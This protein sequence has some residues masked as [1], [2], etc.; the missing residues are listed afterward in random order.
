MMAQDQAKKNKDPLLNPFANPTDDPKLPR[1]L[2]V[3]DSISVG[4][5]TRVRRLLQGKANV[6][7][8]GTNCRWSAFGDENIQDWMK[9]S[10]WD[11]IH[12]NF[13]LWD[14]YGWKQEVKATPESYADR[15]NSIVEK[16]KPTGANLIFALTTPPCVGSERSAKIIVSQER[17][18]AFNDAAIE[19]M[20]R[21]EV[22]IND[23]YTAVGQ[24]RTKYQKA[25]NDVH[26]NDEGRDVLAAKVAST[27]AAALGKRKSAPTKRTARTRVKKPDVYASS[28]PKPTFSEVRYGKHKRHVIDFWQ[29]DSDQPAPLVFVIHGGGWK[30]GSKE[31]VDRFANVQKMLDY[32]ISVAA[33]NYRYVTNA[34][35]DD[36]QPPVKAP[37]HDAA[38]A[39]QF[40]RSKSAEWNID[41]ERIGAAGGSA[42]ACS[43]LWLAFHDDLADPD[44]DDPVARESTR[45]WCA[46][47]NGAQ[48]TLDPKQMKEW[49]PNSRYGGHAFGLGKF[50]E[51]LAKRDT[52]MPWIQEYSPYANVSRD[53][54]PI[55]LFYNAPPAI[56]KEQKDPTHTS[57]F[58]VKLLERCKASGVSCELVYP[59]APNVKHA[60]NS[61]YLI[62]ALTNS[63]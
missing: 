49:T 45:L 4:Y 9:G 51:F 15:L 30:G 42:G 2:I 54:P 32:G 63:E 37:L 1:V 59:N 19:V 21:H 56:G 48:T 40:V 20:K 33:I 3:G 44:S 57:N 61:D 60:N 24:D 22:P 58:G 46:A 6:H 27:I 62:E 53:D 39:L 7:R 26:Y 47:V 10:T 41:K 43:S 34:A 35:E 55:Y 14:W 23:L 36:T 11:V 12:F 25:E 50:P 16:M 17:A 31:R 38:R 29:A 52:I 18:K 13:G 8:V 28:V 5:T